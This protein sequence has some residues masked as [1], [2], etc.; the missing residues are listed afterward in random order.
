MHALHQVAHFDLDIKWSLYKLQYALNHFLN[1]IGI[2]IL[3]IEEVDRSFH[4]RL[5]VKSKK[6]IYKILNRNSPPAIEKNKI[7]H[8]G[9]KLNVQNMQRAIEFLNGKHDFSSFCKKK[10][11]LEQNPIKT[12]D[13]AYIAQFNDQIIFTFVA[14]SFLHNQI[15]IMVG[16]IAEIGKNTLHYKDIINIINAKDRAKAGP[17]APPCGLYLAHIEYLDE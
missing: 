7:W 9:H 12:L 17:T 6:Y 5:K 8:I 13:E 10:S 4:S 16:T 1:G 15:R 11:L 2:S 14:K 3:N